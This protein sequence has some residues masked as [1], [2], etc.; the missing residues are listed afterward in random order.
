MDAK[1]FTSLILFLCKEPEGA[2][3][4]QATGLRSHSEECS[5]ASFI[6][7]C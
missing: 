4:G 1:H 2:Q 3:R 6:P 5:S 7:P